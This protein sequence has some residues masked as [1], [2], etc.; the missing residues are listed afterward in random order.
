MPLSDVE[1]TLDTADPAAQFV[2]YLDYYRSA[3]ERKLDG[4]S[5]EQLRTSTL[6]SGWTPLE[7][8]THLVHMERRW[9][10]W[11]FLGEQ[12][13]DPW[14]DHEGGR[15][16]GPWRVPDGATH[17][18]LVAAL[19]AGGERTRQILGSHDL[20]ERG[21]LG[22]RFESDPPTLTWICFHVLQE[23]ARHV[24]HLDVAR[25]LADGSVGE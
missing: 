11:G 1:P 6:P 23:Y 10:V 2:A 12:V 14:G 20:A 19:H 5:D 24:G 21:A 4:L 7:L 15:P 17:P 16:E 22:G 18:G 25:E 8:L 9:F 3:V 13:P